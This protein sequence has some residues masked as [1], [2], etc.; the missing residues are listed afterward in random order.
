MY[1]VDRGSSGFVRGGTAM[2]AALLVFV[3][4]GGAL[5]A[6]GCDSTGCG[7]YNA[8]TQTW[9]PVTGCID[10]AQCDTSD[11]CR[12]TVQ[13]GLVRLGYALDRRALLLCAVAVIRGPTISAFSRAL[14]RTQKT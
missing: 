9:Q 3:L 10:Q 8:T 11:G 4:V 12:W 2:N 14:A 6:N 13:F 5:A 7:R 1:V